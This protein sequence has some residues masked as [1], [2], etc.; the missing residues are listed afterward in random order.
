MNHGPRRRIVQRAMGEC[1]FRIRQHGESG[2]EEFDRAAADLPQVLRELADLL[3]HPPADTGTRH[4]APALEG[5]SLWA[6][7]YDEEMDNPVVL[8][9]EEAI[10]EAIGVVEGLSVLD[11]GCGTGRH[12][13]PL[14]A[15]GARVV[16]LDPTPEMLD[17]ARAKAE[18]A[19]A[20]LEL[21]IG[22]IDSLDD[23]VGEFD[24]VLCCLVLSHTEALSDA[25]ARL[26]SRVAPGGRLIVTD[27]HPINLLLGFRTAFTH[28]G[29]RYIVPSFLHPVSEYFAALRDAGLVV[30][31]IDEL[32]SWERLPGVPTTLL[33]EAART[34]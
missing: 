1:L 3:E 25:M 7:S 6:L 24:L 10:R 22:G 32:G 14:A 28:E 21:R 9:E 34:L 19:G 33:M 5:Y 30:T 31:R 29:R 18:A 11:V 20:D 2:E 13:V 26:A 12:A 15:Q 27:F 4:E 8:G 16:G 23:R 17:R